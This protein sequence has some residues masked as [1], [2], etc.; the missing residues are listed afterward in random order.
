M[1]ISRNNFLNYNRILDN[2]FKS[3]MKLYNFYQN[4]E[5]GEIPVLYGWLFFKN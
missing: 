3:E 2:H 4:N 5:L 1:S